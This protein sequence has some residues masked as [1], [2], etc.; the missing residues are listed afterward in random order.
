MK[1]TVFC[2]FIAAWWMPPNFMAYN[3]HRLIAHD[4]TGWLY[5]FSAWEVFA[6]ILSCSCSQLGA[7]LE[8][9]GW[10]CSL[11]SS[12]VHPTKFLYDLQVSAEVLFPSSRHPSLQESVSSLILELLLHGPHH[13]CR[14]HVCLPHGVW[15]LWGQGQD[16]CIHHCIC[17]DSTCL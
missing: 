7:G 6:L 17:M 5:G 4:S 3:N 16:Y 13:M 11:P 15:A 1:A 12:L 14:F 9:P 2:L 10:L 8:H